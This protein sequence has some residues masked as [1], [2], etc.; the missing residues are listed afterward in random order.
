MSPPSRIDT[1]SCSYHARIGAFGL[2]WDE[3]DDDPHTKTLLHRSPLCPHVQ[4]AQP[5][6][7]S[8][9]P[10]RGACLCA[11]HDVSLSFSLASMY[12][13]KL[14]RRGAKQRLV[15]TGFLQTTCL[16]IY[17][18]RYFCIDVSLI[19]TGSI[20]LVALNY[21]FV[22]AT[23]SLFKFSVPSRLRSLL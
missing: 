4:A 20:I 3:G 17:F 10:L 14:P 18:S 9:S 12:V 21:F 22:L 1:S 23:C 15:M 8:H 6:P 7:P 5:T 16:Y 13:N 19:C 11:F 2:D